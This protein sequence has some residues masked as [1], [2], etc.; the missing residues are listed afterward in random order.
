MAMSNDL[1]SKPEKGN[2]FASN[3][4]SSSHT[5]GIRKSQSQ[6]FMT[7]KRLTE[8]DEKGDSS[9]PKSIGSS[10]EEETKIEINEAKL[11]DMEAEFEVIE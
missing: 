2:S 1:P 4:V 5:A 6:F 7:G 11:T 8:V 10:R 9:D 3:K